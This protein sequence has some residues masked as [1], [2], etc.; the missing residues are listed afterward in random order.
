MTLLHTIARN[1]VD[2]YCC[3]LLF[4]PQGSCL[5]DCDCCP[6]YKATVHAVSL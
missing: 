6:V 2:Q 1:K 4:S 5:L 3:S